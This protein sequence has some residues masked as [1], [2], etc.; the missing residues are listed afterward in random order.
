MRQNG[1]TC[2]GQCQAHFEAVTWK[3][4]HFVALLQQP[5]FLLWFQSELLWYFYGAPWSTVTKGS[6]FVTSIGALLR[7]GAV[8]SLEVLLCCMR[9]LLVTSIGASMQLAIGRP[10]TWGR[11]VQ[12]Y[13]IRHIL[14][15]LLDSWAEF[16]CSVTSIVALLQGEAALLPQMLLRCNWKWAG[17][18]YDAE[19]SNLFG[20][21]S[22]AYWNCYLEVEPTCGFVATGPF[23]S[24]QFLLCFQ[25]ELL[26]YFN[27]SFNAL[28]NRQSQHMRQNGAIC[29]GQRQAH[30]KAV[31]WKLS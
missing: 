3:L 14:K 21:M 2:R 8:L 12:L 6:C 24:P 28:G 4:S 17:L 20:T 22:S 11:T 19:Q 25:R 30:F 16:R 1:T 7:Q 23:L 5:Q 13:N 18:A 10:I 29:Q 15:P 31:T 27:C 26:P 9:E